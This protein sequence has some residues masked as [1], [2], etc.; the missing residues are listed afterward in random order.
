MRVSSLDLTAGSR[1]ATIGISGSGKTTLMHTIFGI[2]CALS[3]L[4]ENIAPAQW[5]VQQTPVLL[6]FR[7]VQENVVLPLELD[8]AL[9]PER[10]DLAVNHLSQLGLKEAR[11]VAPAQLSGGMIKR[12]GLAQAITS[13]RPL[14]GVDEPFSGVDARGRM[15]AENLVF[16]QLGSAQL[17]LFIAH[18]LDSVVSLAT[19]IIV[20][21][22]IPG[23][24]VKLVSMSDMGFPD[25][26]SPSI[27]RSSSKFLDML[28]NVQ[29]LLFQEK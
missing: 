11:G 25:N 2:Q 7:S 14:V 4:I 8:G 20:V 26:D 28:A 18:D 10:V 1:V 27:R 12:V 15:N 19:Q 21:P 13:G 23:G 22:S 5:L 24:E 16:D 9:S 17:F 6:S 3:G 29:R